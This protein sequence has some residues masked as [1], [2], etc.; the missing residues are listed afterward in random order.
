VSHVPENN[1]L[2][3]PTVFQHSRH[4]VVKEQRQV[5]RGL[6]FCFTAME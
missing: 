3:V 1:R 2:I 5:S 4:H 6:P